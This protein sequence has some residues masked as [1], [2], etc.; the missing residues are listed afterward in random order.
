MLY[1]EA[2]EIEVSDWSMSTN[3]NLIPGYFRWQATCL[4]LF[5]EEGPLK[6][7]MV[8]SIEIGY[9]CYGCLGFYN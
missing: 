8:G 3:L 1:F 2:S 4:K 5:K 9:F 6:G 7:L